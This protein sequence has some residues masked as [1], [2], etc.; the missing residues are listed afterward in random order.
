M[1]PIPMEEEAVKSQ[2]LVVDTELQ[3]L[4]CDL[5]KI[6]VVHFGSTLSF[7]HLQDLYKRNQLSD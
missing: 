5:T 6:R 1:P 4:L 2:L 3:R 7:E